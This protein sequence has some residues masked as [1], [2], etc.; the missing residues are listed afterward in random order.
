[1][2]VSGVGIPSHYHRN[3]HHDH[4]THHRLHAQIQRGPRAKRLASLRLAPDRITIERNVKWNF[5]KISADFDVAVGIN[6]EGVWDQNAAVRV[7]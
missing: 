4:N 3:T 5:R 6:Y 2:Y 1:M 7:P